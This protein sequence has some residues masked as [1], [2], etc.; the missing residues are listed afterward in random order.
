[1]KTNTELFADYIEKHPS[2]LG[3]LRLKQLME[4]DDLCLKCLK[5]DTMLCNGYRLQGNA[6]GDVDLNACHRLE[7]NFELQD[8][9]RRAIASGIGK[10]KIRAIQETE[11]EHYPFDVTYSNGGFCRQNN[12]KQIY[13][14]N[15]G[16]FRYCAETTSV[17][18]Q[19]LL[20]FVDSGLDCRYLF[21]LQLYQDPKLLE[22]EILFSDTNLLAAMHEYVNKPE[23]LHVEALDYQG[24]P[25]IR[26]TMLKCL[27]LRLDDMRMTTVSYT[28]LEAKNDLEDNVYKEISTWNQLATL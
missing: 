13:Y 20:N 6:H 10:K 5:G 21:T 24:N 22:N 16:R 4:L 1:M 2:K 25:R 14:P 26:Q 28:S 19:H 12:G 17:V 15:T 18:K 27:R 3:E 8:W 23:W 11:T 9:Q 7:E